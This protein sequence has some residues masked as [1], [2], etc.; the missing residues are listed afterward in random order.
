[1]PAFKITAELNTAVKYGMPIKHILLNNSEL[2]KIT[3]EQRADHFDVWQT[4]LHN[5]NFAE[6]ATHCGAF[7]IRIDN[8]SELS[9]ALQTLFDHNGPGMV[10]IITDTDLI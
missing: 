10:E 5:P 4:S 9:T 8:R 3:K 2:G 6:Y 1:L 7:G